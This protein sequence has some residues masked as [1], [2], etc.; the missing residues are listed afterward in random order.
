MRILA[1]MAP[2]AVNS[3]NLGPYGDAIT[4][5]LVPYIEKR[6]KPPRQGWARFVYST[7]GSWGG[8][9]TPTFYPDEYKGAW[10]GFCPRLE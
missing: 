2:Y 6:S 4:Y 1:T 3:T 5:E 10:F 7:T 8:A 9:R